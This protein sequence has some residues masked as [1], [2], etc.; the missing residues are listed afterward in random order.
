M[1]DNRASTAAR[2]LADN[3]DEK[4]VLSSDCTIC[5]ARLEHDIDAYYT[6][7]ATSVGTGGLSGIGNLPMSVKKSCR[8]IRYRDCT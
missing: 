8:E 5:F 4:N 7:G 6:K 1:V 3:L 2:K